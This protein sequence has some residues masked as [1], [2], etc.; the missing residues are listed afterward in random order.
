MKPVEVTPLELCMAC[1]EELRTMLIMERPRILVP[2]AYTGNWIKAARTVWPSAYI[3]GLELRSMPMPAG[4]DQWRQ[5]DWIRQPQLVLDNDLVLGNPEA[6]DRDRWVAAGYQSLTFRGWQGYVLPLNYLSGQRRKKVWLSYPLRYFYVIGPRPSF[7]A[8]SYQNDKGKWKQPGD[9]D[10]REYAFYVWKNNYVGDAGLR[11]MSW[12]RPKVTRYG[13]QNGKAS[14]DAPSDVSL[15]TLPA[16]AEAGAT[17]TQGNG[18]ED[19][20]VQLR[21]ELEPDSDA[22]A[23]S[24]GV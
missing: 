23:G 24:S 18:G 16:Q 2:G 3:T 5:A 10:A 20:P 6:K 15:S 4:A 14:A 12:A 8:E 21:L 7:I 17:D 22:V 19:R 1:C 13:H 11:F 9:T